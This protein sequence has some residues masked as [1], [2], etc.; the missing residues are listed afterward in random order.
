MARKLDAEKISGI[1]YPVIV[2]E[3]V[4]SPGVCHVEC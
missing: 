3:Q 2:K 1:D 4:L